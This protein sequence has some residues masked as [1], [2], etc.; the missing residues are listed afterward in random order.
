MSQID[1]PT[2]K[3]SNLASWRYKSACFV[4]SDT[5]KGIQS[6]IA[7]R[8]AGKLKKQ[9]TK[10]NSMNTKKKRELNYKEQAGR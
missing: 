10:K 8:A 1:S 7:K 5:P 6:K 2:S 3:V 9:R 4:F